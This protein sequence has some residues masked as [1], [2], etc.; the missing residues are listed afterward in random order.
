MLKILI[1]FIAI[2]L[3]TSVLIGLNG[4]FTLMERFETLEDCL[5]AKIYYHERGMWAGG[6]R[7]MN[8]PIETYNDE[9]GRA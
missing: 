9:R 8:Q 3:L 6:C 2:Y 4:P 5:H 1:K 7:K